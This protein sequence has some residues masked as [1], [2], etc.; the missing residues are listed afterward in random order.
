MADNARKTSTRIHMSM[1]I[2]RVT[3]GMTQDKNTPTIQAVFAGDEARDNL[4]L[5]QHYGFASSPLPGADGIA[6]FQSG[7][8]NKG[9]VIATNDQRYRIKSL[10]SGEVAIYDKSGSFITLKQDG[11]IEIS[12][13]NKKMTIN[14]DIQ[15][16]GNIKV[17]EDIDV[18][19]IKASGDV[20][21]GSISLKTH[22]HPNGNNGS[23]T[24]A[25][26]S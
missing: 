11:S 15:V 17:T 20:K 9:V 26:T 19:N 1:G 10:N 3:N 12:P 22:Q 6:I 25:P 4:T 24:G 14:S 16:N 8:R 13:K 7:D 18:Q 23:P 21:A 5:M 2:C